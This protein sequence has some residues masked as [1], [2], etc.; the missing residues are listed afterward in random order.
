MSLEFFIELGCE[1]IP[2]RLIPSLLEQLATKIVGALDESGVSHLSPQLY[3]TPRRLVIQ[4][5]QVSEKQPDRREAI[6]GP[7]LSSAYDSEGQ[8]T[9]AAL[10][11]ANKYQVTLDQVL[12]IDTGKGKYLGF[13]KNVPG[14]RTIVLLG[15]AMPRLLGELQFPKG[16]RWEQSRF[17]F[18][19]PI[20]WVLCLL[21]GEV[22]PFLVAGTKSSNFT[23]GH[24]FLA[25]NC[26]VIVYNFTD[27]SK[28]MKDLFVVVNPSQR[29]D[30]IRMDL[31]AT[32]S[33]HGCKLLQDEA[34]LGQVTHL[35]EYP[36]V[37]SGNFESRFLSLPREVLVTVMREHQKYFSMV[38]SDE[39][40]SPKF[41]AVVDSEP[42]FAA[43]IVSGHER[44]L[45]ARLEDASF[46]WEVDRRVSLESRVESLK[47]IVFQAELGT[48]FEKTQRL[49]KLVEA[50]AH[51]LGCPDRV[52][53]L[54]Q[55]ARLCKTDLTTEMVKEF[56][57]L[58][59]VM[60]GLYSKTQ[61]VSEA[62][63]TAICEHYQ[64]NS[65]EDRPPQSVEGAVLSI[66]DKLDSIVGLFSVGLVSSGSKDPL[67][68]R[69]QT[70]GILNVIFDKRLSVS[71][72]ALFR[73]AF[74]L[75]RKKAKRNYAE[76]SAELHLFF[77]ERLRNVFRDMGYRY[78]EI[79]AIVAIGVDNPL[80]CL[81]KVSAISAMRGSEDF[82]AVSLSF[83]R[84]KN[85]VLKAGLAF[86]SPFTIDPS[87]FEVEEERALGQLVAQIKPK[88]KRAAA[89]HDFRKAFEL[90]ASLRP[91]ID[92]FFDKVL[93]MAENPEVQKNRLS[94]LGSLLG[95]FYRLADVSEV[96]L[97]SAVMSA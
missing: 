38:D 37:V 93:V 90:M 20:R 49:V 26:K 47:R 6:T 52:E 19:R 51:L 10:G 42:R 67:G 58:Q 80:E 43:T 96:V 31:E 3:A 53:T 23:F 55:A 64:P 84:I 24:R 35:H 34:L 17:V 28:K 89:R 74:A 91:S 94:L 63:A 95:V 97:D 50:L 12:A 75:V 7:P 68:L 32:C 30:G 22:V 81:E 44:V 69:R 65:W 79:N 16:M 70:L 92:L 1:E 59:G 86:D 82:Y 25:N 56:T 71:L 14:V 29:Q 66:A 8:P 78:D 60:G 72:E 39:K 45:K 5:E 73:K 15:D 46:Y 18:V 88:V 4:I 57:G 85:I 83:K 33:S 41:L 54:R 48:M 62:A 11:F 40:L 87:L 36:L 13:E 27:Y 61:G 77:K 21:G 9:K 76:V 2:A